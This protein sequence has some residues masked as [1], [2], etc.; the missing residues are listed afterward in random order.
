MTTHQIRNGYSVCGGITPAGWYA[1]VLVIEDF[2]FKS[3]EA[4]IPPGFE[5]RVERCRD[6]QKR[7]VNRPRRVVLAE[8]GPDGLK[9]TEL[10][11]AERIDGPAC[12]AEQVP[13]PLVAWTERRNGG[14]SLQIYHEM[15]AR[16]V[17]HQSGTLRAPQVA[18]AYEGIVVACERDAAGGSPEVVLFRMDGREIF[19]SPGRNPRLAATAGGIALLT[20]QCTTNGIHLK[21]TWLEEGRVRGEQE[22]RGGDYTF[23]T[24][25]AWSG[26]GQDVFVAA[27]CCPAFGEGSQFGKHRRIFVWRCTRGSVTPLSGAEG[28]GLPV[29]PRAFQSI[30]PENLPPIRPQLF[31]EEGRPVVAFRQFRYHGFKTFGW[32]VF[33][34][35]WDGTAWAAPVRLSPCLCLPDA[36]ACVRPAGRRYVGMFPAIEND[37]RAGRTYGHRVEILEFDGTHRLDRFEIGEQKKRPYAIPKGYKDIGLEAP[38]LPAPYPGRTLVWGDLHV[39]SAYSKCVGAVDGSPAEKLRFARDAIDCRVFT[40]TEHTQSQSWA[41]VTWCMDQ[42][43]KEAGDSGVVLYGT[44]PG[45]RTGRHT[46]F[47]AAD[48]DIFER[49][50]A[51]LSMHDTDRLLIYRHIREELPPGSVFVLQH[52]HGESP[53]DAEMLQS[54]DPQL[55][56]A[57]EAMQGR[58]NALFDPRD[59]APHFPTPFLNMGCKIGLVGGMDHYREGPNRFCLTGFWVREISARGVWEAIRNRYTLA[60]ANAKIAMATTLDG[61]PMGSSVAVKDGGPVRVQLSASCARG[62]HRATLIRDGEMLPW[63]SVDSLSAGIELIDAAPPP[64]RHWY[65]PTVETGSAFGGEAP[66]YAHASP[67]FVLC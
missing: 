25:L 65:V 60:A 44:E 41:E 62:I 8:P 10:A 9:Q 13:S 1:G 64:G 22:I 14:W 53:D 29:E 33:W 50:V 37:G 52:F 23:N 47:Y 30:G 38:P 28:D 18:Y 11:A 3:F 6:L 12:P 21:L 36:A 46:N 55:E 54:F 34:C 31:V 63:I 39:H 19:R 56:V 35:R 51:I 67:F 4:E 16:P 66:G 27:E 57:M 49:L 42:L 61:Q 48:R 58:C 24:D 59:D 32:D 45:L 7:F 15:K 2:D 20:E 43:E 26:A 17:I 40:L 5:E